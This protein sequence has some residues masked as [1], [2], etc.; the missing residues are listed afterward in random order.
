MRQPI[1]RWSENWQCGENVRKTKELIVDYR[2]RRAGQAPININRAVVEWVE[3]FKFLGVYIT[4]ELSLS[5]HTKRAQHNLFPFRRLE[6]FGMGPQILKK[7]Y[8]CTIESI[9]TICITTRY[10][11]CLAYDR[12]TLQ[13]VV[14]STEY[15]PVHHWGQDSCNP[16]PI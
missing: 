16:E 5:K 7:L 1:G 11:N 6:R 9:L 8:S 12:K 3:S 14:P 2:K 13:R 15:G 4:N 10:Y